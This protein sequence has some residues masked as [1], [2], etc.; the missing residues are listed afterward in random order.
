MNVSRVLVVGAIAGILTFSAGCSWFRS[1][2]DIDPSLQGVVPGPAAGPDAMGGLGKGGPGGTDG[3]FGAGGNGE[4]LSPGGFKSG[5]GEGLA[6]GAGDWKVID[7]IH[8][9]I[10]YFAYDQDSIGASERPKLEQVASY[11]TKNGSLGLIVEGNCDERGSAEYNRALGERRALSIKQ[12]LGG[13]GVSEER[14]KTIS[15]GEERPAVQGSTPEAY[16]KNRRGE[17]KAAEMK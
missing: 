3:A 5:G 1:S 11:L 6:G 12:Y 7:S 14:I 8:F 17:L 13:L 10:I 16:A 4:S 2:E 9:P 15:Y